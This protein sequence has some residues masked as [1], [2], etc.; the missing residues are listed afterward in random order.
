[1]S[2]DYFYGTGRR[3]KAA[4]A[5]RSTTPARPDP[6]GR[7]MNG[8]ITHIVRGQGHGFIRVR[9]DRNIYF[10]RGDVQDGTRFNDLEVGDAV[11]FELLEDQISG[12]R[13]LRVTRGDKRRSREA[14]ERSQTGTVPARTTKRRGG[15]TE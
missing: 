13:A 10:H 8:R 15:R 1:M 4:T 2:N 7:P 9:G 5:K 14:S 3:S 11:L 6:R 12:P